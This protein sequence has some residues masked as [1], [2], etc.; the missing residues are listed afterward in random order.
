ML[1][2]NFAVL[3]LNDLLVFVNFYFINF[4]L[5]F[6][7]LFVCLFLWFLFHYCCFV[8]CIVSSSFTGILIFFMFSFYLLKLFLIYNWSINLLLFNRRFHS[9]RLTFRL[10]ETTGRCYGCYWSP[11]TTCWPLRFAKSCFSCVN[12]WHSFPQKSAKQN[13][14]K[15]K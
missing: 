12:A 11:I 9:Y 5:W 7:D 13:Q 4:V 6:D 10:P 15:A 3:S 8:I 14:N 1:C 2:F